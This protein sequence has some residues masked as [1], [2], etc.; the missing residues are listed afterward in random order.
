M[1]IGPSAHVQQ[2]TAELARLG[3]ELLERCLEDVPA[4]LAAARPQTEEGV[5]LGETTRDGLAGDWSC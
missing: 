3:S 2:L 1:A 4:A 5:T